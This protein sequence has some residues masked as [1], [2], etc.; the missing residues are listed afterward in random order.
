MCLRLE[1]WWTSRSNA[2]D[3]RPPL[4]METDCDTLEPPEE[5]VNCTCR[6]LSEMAGGGGGKLLNITTRSPAGRF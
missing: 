5:A 3:P 4:P 6:R 1:W 2:R